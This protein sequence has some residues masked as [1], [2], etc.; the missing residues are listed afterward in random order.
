VKLPTLIICALSLPGVACPAGTLDW[1]TV[2]QDIARRF[3]Q[4]RQLPASELAAW[5]SD[6]NQPAPLLLDVRTPA[7]YAVSHLANARQV[8]PDADAAKALPDTS[9][10]TLIVTYCSVGYR[11]SAFAERL[12]RAGFTN[13]FQL[14]GSIFQWANEG[15]RLVRDGKPVEKVHPYNARWGQLLDTERRAR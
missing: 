15:R 10:D 13:V 14:D 1:P 3:P 9:K 2:K 5:L 7:E 4:V 12:R 8:D 6:T 11:S